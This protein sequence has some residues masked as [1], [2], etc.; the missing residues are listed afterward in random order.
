[1][2][3]PTITAAPSSTYTGHR[4]RG[5]G[6]SAA[7]IRPLAGQTAGVRPVPNGNACPTS[8][9]AI[10]TMTKIRYAAMSALRARRPGMRLAVDIEQ[11]RRVHVGVPLRR[12][13][14]HVAEQLLD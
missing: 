8:T 12:R 9:P 6:S 10:M 14:L 5:S 4:R 2:I 11:L 13:Q 1:M 3:E 7:S